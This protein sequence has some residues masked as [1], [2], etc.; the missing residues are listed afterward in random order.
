MGTAGARVSRT[1]PFLA[2]PNRLLVAPSIEPPKSGL[3]IANL[4]A[5][6]SAD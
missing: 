5:L 6:R 4:Q 1:R 3:R 2:I